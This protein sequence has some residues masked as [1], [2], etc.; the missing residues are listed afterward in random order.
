MKMAFVGG[1]LFVLA[2]PE[3]RSENSDSSQISMNGIYL[4]FYI[5]RHDFSDG[6]F[7]INYER[8]LGKKRRSQLRFGIYP[9]F[10]SSIA[11]P[12]TFTWITKPARSHH[13]EYGIGAVFRIEHH[14]DPYILTQSREWFFDM[15][16]AMVPLMYRY[17]KS[18]GWFFRGGINLFLSW[19]TLPS[20]SFSIGYKF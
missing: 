18:H 2:V 9:D 11:F 4:E 8:V 6:F 1:I 19:P 12:T 10:G 13:F 3:I 5:V 15:P 16:A 14:V 7:S 17:Q 20:P